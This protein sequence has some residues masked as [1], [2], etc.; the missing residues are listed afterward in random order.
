VGSGKLVPFIG[1]RSANTIGDTGSSSV[2]MDLLDVQVFVSSVVVLLVML[3]ES[4]SLISMSRSFVSVDMSLLV[5]MSVRCISVM[6]DPRFLV[7]NPLVDLAGMELAYSDDT[8]G[9]RFDVVLLHDMLDM[10]LHGVHRDL[11][12]FLQDMVKRADDLNLGVHRS[13]G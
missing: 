8:P 10:F 7:V 6:N 4:D 2:H 3:L 12:R 5:V 1:S 9:H 13:A 11:G